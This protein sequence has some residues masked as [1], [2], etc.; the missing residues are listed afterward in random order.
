[1]QFRFVRVAVGSSEVRRRAGDIGG[2]RA[3]GQVRRLRASSA[4]GQY[5]C[6]VDR[7]RSRDWKVAKD[8]FLVF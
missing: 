2:H 5:V 4:S 3:E 6:S 8:Y 7:S 1:M